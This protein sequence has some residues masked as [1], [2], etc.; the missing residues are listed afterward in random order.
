MFFVKSGQRPKNKKPKHSSLSLLRRRC[1]AST[2]TPHTMGGT[3]P[4]KRPPATA[5]PTEPATKRGATTTDA[6]PAP[7]PTDV[8]APLTP[9]RRVNVIEVGGDGVNL[10]I[11]VRRRG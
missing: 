3:R 2:P 9:D 4:G 10:C 5:A 1:R 11:R 7:P 6:S 8:A